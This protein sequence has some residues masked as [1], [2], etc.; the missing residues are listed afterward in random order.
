MDFLKAAIRRFSSPLLLFVAVSLTLVTANAENSGPTRADR[1]KAASI[2]KFSRY[3]HWV[4]TE[5]NRVISAGTSICILGTDPYDGALYAL[6][7]STN[8]SVRPV[9]NSSQTIGCHI[10]VISQSEQARL[11]RVLR[12]MRGKRLVTISEIDGFTDQGGMIRLYTKNNRIRFDVNQAAA[13]EVQLR[14]D[15][16]L[17]RLAASVVE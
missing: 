7:G 2:Y 4:D 10:L 6:Q 12:D 13:R 8:I 9:D 1:M 3:I 17:T 15:L 14:F 11:H 5:D 16:R